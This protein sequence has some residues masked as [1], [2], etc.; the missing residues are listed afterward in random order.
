[1]RSSSALSLLTSST[2][3]CQEYSSTTGHPIHCSFHNILS[4][5]FPWHP[6]EA[7]ATCKTR[8]KGMGAGCTLA[9]GRSSINSNAFK[10]HVRVFSCRSFHPEDPAGKPSSVRFFQHTSRNAFDRFD[11]P[12]PSIFTTMNPGSA[13]WC[14][15][16]TGGLKL[17]AV[18]LSWGPA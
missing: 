11:V 17:F 15:D 6:D 13:S 16:V 5:L 18:K 1:M 10:I 4:I 2:F 3:D 8:E 9:S 12:I 7:T 14:I